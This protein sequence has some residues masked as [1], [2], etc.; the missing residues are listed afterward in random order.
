MKVCGPDPVGGF[1]VAGA[2][3]RD[4]LPVSGFRTDVQGLQAL[5]EA[6]GPLDTTA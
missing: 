1:L 3:P 5:I 6:E 2:Q 4:R